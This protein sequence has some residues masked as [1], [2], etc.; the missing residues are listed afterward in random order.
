MA[1]T[2]LE[3]HDDLP[4]V[5]VLE[6]RDDVDVR[7]TADGRTA[8]GRTVHI[9]RTTDT[10]PDDFASHP[11]WIFR[12]GSLDTGPGL[13]P[14]W[15]QGLVPVRVGGGRSVLEPLM[16]GGM[17]HQFEREAGGRRVE[18]LGE[19]SVLVARR[20]SGSSR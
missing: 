8:D 1:V 16:R 20:S 19:F 5:I 11:G 13:D 7:R 14:P 3:W 9:Y 17:R 2:P 18:V 12:I 4:D 6:S 15:P 10:I